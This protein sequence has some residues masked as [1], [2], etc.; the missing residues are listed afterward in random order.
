M[1]QNSETFVQH[2]GHCNENR[3]N[4]VWVGTPCQGWRLRGWVCKHPTGGITAA[5]IQGTFDTFWL[6]PGLDGIPRASFLQ[7]REY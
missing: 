5:S 6:F 4:C 7:P 2:Q 1:A 3:E